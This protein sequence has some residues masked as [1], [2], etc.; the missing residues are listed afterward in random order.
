MGA[1][2][3]DVNAR[4]LIRC[5]LSSCRYTIIYTETVGHRDGIHFWRKRKAPDAAFVITYSTRDMVRRIHHPDVLNAAQAA[6]EGR[7]PQGPHNKENEGR[8][9]LEATVGSKNRGE[10]KDY[11]SLGK[12]QGNPRKPATAIARYRQ[13]TI[14]EMMLNLR[15]HISRKVQ[16]EGRRRE[17]LSPDTAPG[18]V[19]ARRQNNPSPALRMDFEMVTE[20]LSRASPI[21]TMSKEEGR[22]GRFECLRELREIENANETGSDS[23]NH[24]QTNEAGNDPADYKQRSEAEPLA[25]FEQKVLSV[26]PSTRIATL[27]KK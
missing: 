22:G 11:D 16:P 4:D 10:E 15:E 17:G 26:S 9:E 7:V 6:K 13:L 2:Y 18:N 25:V 21:R 19:H 27:S 20:S 3:H 8:D 12:L 1:R 5:S 23:A 24:K 14:T